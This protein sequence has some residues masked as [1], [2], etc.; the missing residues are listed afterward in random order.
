MDPSACETNLV[1]PGRAGWDWRSGQGAGEEQPRPLFQAELQV[2]PLLTC[3]G[4]GMGQGK[5]GFCLRGQEEVTAISTSFLM[6]LRPPFLALKAYVIPVHPTS[7]QEF[8]PNLCPLML[9]SDFSKS[10][11]SMW[12]W[13]SLS[14]ETCVVVGAD[15]G[16]SVRRL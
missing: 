3:C 14:L 7:C 5:P 4:G 15:L 10:A 12:A 13:T 6:A 9:L 16:K 1:Q 2:L 8:C 11:R